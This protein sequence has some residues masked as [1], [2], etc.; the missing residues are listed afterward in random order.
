VDFV[1]AS[2]LGL[3]DGRSVPGVWRGVASGWLGR[4]ALDGG[5]ASSALGVATHFAIA[6]VMAAAYVLLAR[7]IPP[8]RRRPLLTAP[9]YGLILYGVMYGLVL[10]LRWPQAFPRWDG[11]QSMLDILTHMGVAL[12]IAWVAARP[13]N[14]PSA[15]VPARSSIGD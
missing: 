5:L 7:R 9:I 1:Y 12:A 4:S 10:P 11:A 6:T 15:A 13:A 3:L 8:V 14:A 2:V